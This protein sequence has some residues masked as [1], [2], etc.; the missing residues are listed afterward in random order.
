MKASIKL[1]ALILCVIMLL[2]TFSFAYHDRIVANDPVSMPKASP[3]ILT[4]SL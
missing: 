1:T 4:S 3:T 2:P